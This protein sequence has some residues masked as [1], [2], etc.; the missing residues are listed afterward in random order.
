MSTKSL[1]VSVAM[2]VALCTST[3]VLANEIDKGVAGVLLFNEY[4]GEGIPPNV[5]NMTESYLK[6][7]Y[8][9]VMAEAKA[10]VDKMVSSGIDKKT[11]MNMWCGLMRPKLTS[12]FSS[13]N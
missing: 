6:T 8:Q 10:L 7:R 3:P 9:P 11:V 5:M 2:L 4:C 13:M 12:I 1:Y